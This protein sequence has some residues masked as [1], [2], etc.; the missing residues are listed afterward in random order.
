MFVVL[1]SWLRDIARVHPIHAIDA[2]QRQMAAD[3]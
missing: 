3:R 1:S 2:E